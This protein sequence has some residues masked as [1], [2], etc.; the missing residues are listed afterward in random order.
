MEIDAYN[1][2]NGTEDSNFLCVKISKNIMNIFIN[3]PNELNEIPKLGNIDLKFDL[4][5]YIVN[6]SK[7]IN[8][9]IGSRLNGN[10]LNSIKAF[11]CNFI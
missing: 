11:Y 10:F 5:T 6:N 3:E 8:F 9:L 7:D 1:I 4:G 2:L